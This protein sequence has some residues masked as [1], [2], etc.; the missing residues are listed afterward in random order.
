[1]T[2]IFHLDNFIELAEIFIAFIA[3]VMKEV[4]PNIERNLRIRRTTNNA[5]LIILSQTK[6]NDLRLIPEG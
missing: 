6:N 3:C 1:M 2:H 4:D 5:I